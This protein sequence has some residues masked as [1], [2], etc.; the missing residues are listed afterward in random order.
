MVE[1]NEVTKY[2]FLYPQVFPYTWGALGY[3]LLYIAGD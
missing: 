1:T 2:E 3:I